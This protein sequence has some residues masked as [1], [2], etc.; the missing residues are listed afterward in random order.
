MDN[1]KLKVLVADDHPLFR[2]GLVAALKRM[3]MISKI[4]TAANGEEVIRLLEN[5][6][7]DVIL[8]DIGM[9]PMDGIQ[10]TLII[11]SR[12]PSA[13]VIALS[14]YDDVKSVTSMFEMGASGYLLKNADTDEIEY[15]IRAVAEGGKYFYK[16]VSAALLEHIENQKPE[17]NAPK[18]SIFHKHRIREIIFLISYE[19]TSVEIG[20]AISLASRTIDDYRKEIL[21]MTKSRNTA[22]IVKYAITHH[23]DQD[24]QLKNKFKNFLA[25]KELLE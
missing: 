25:K 19:L 10:A 21:S 9:K 4:S 13:K 14:M 16:E 8:M 11:H 7:H 22:G 20:N 23:I 18:E 15:A 12:F 17:K 24:I 5:E 2:N 3:K 1:S 6:F